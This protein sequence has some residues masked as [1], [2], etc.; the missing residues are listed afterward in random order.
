M[1]KFHAIYGKGGSSSGGNVTKLVKS[2]SIGSSDLNNITID[3][4]NDVSNYN[5]ITNDNIIIE[6]T[7]IASKAAAVA[8]LNHTYN[9]DTGIITITSSSNDLPFA[10][11][12]ETTLNLNVFLAG[13]VVIPPV[14]KTALTI[15]KSD[16]TTEGATTTFS[17]IVNVGQLAILSAGSGD[18]NIAL[19][20]A[21]GENADAQ[22]WTISNKKAI[23]GS[24]RGSAKQ[25]SS[26]DNV[27]LGCL[28]VMPTEETGAISVSRTGGSTTW[29]GISYII[30]D[31]N[32]A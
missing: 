6:F 10:S 19:N 16:K 27:S 28:V 24:I 3:I 11:T 13:E 17:F 2:V 1:S 29:T 8:K 18:I 12:S 23:L 21:S 4:S 25:T 31:I 30:L 5:S 20:F 26:D 14:R 7:D 9:A 22:G 15:S 32:E